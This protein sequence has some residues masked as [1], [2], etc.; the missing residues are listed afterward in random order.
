MR[1]PQVLIE[2]SET[3]VSIM[4]SLTSVQDGGRESCTSLHP[5]HG[6]TL[7]QYHKS[8][9]YALGRVDLEGEALDL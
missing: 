8:L 3:T 4:L 5:G 7:C 6:G 1:F 2:H 9:C